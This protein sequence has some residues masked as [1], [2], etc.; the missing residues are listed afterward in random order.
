[1]P[2]KMIGH[3]KVDRFN[4]R[5]GK[6]MAQDKTADTKRHARVR[7]DRPSAAGHGRAA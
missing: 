2:V 4:F 1:M 5:P 7:R 3:C 6:K